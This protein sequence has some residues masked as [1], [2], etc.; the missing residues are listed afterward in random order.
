[1]GNEHTFVELIP[2]TS[3]V[4]SI[5]LLNWM[6]NAAFTGTPVSLL[7]GLVR[8]TV[9]G[10][11]SAIAFVVKV[12]LKDAAMGTPVVVRNAVAVNV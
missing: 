12:P 5:G 2:V 9:G 4:P 3:V 7:N 6:V 8:V 1:M 10:V 11:R